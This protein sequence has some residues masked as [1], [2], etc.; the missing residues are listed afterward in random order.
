LTRQLDAET[1]APDGGQWRAS[2]SA[3]FVPEA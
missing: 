3:H 2:F 1:P